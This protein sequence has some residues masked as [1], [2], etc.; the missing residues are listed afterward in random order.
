MTN[1]I[2]QVLNEKDLDEILM[3]YPHNLSIIMFSSKTCMPCKKF[4]PYFVSGA[5]KFKDC[6]FIYIDLHQFEQTEYKYT[7]DVECTPKF[8]FY[9]DNKPIAD[10]LGGDKDK[11]FESVAFLEN[12]ITEKKKLIQSQKNQQEKNNDEYY[13][14]V[15]MIGK[16]SGLAALGFNSSKEFTHVDKFEDMVEE[17]N[18]LIKKIQIMNEHK[19]NENNLIKNE[20]KNSIDEKINDNTNINNINLNN[21]DLNNKK[22]DNINLDNTNFNNTNDQI[23]NVNNINNK[24]N[25][26]HKN[27]NN[28]STF[29][30]IELEK[31]KKI[32]QLE[33]LNKINQIIEMQQ[34]SQ[35]QQLKNIQRTKKEME[36]KTKLEYGKNRKND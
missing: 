34:L 35:I 16:L 31:Q 10:M 18:M 30:T 5:Q 25:D 1:N 15:Y 11:F 2:Y 4:K 9:F 17:Y 7:K 3:N 14:K 29:D 8:I 28:V 32:K 33:E 21:T 24:I 23:N 13:K 36:E 19:N 22:L 12:K 6:F 27:I 20:N 26:I